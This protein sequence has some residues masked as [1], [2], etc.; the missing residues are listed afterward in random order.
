VCVSVYLSVCLSVCLS[1]SICVRVS[2][3]E[4]A[5]VYVYIVYAAGMQVC[6]TG[7][8]LVLRHIMNVHRQRF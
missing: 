1:V 8:G 3:R 4:S 6:L 7:E 2:V 5:C